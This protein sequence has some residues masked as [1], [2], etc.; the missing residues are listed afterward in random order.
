MAL[1]VAVLLGLAGFTAAP[2]QIVYG[3]GFA[4]SA[5][6]PHVRVTGGLLGRPVYP[7]PYPVYGFAPGFVGP[8]FPPP[9]GPSVLVPPWVYPPPLVGAPN[10][11]G[12]DYPAGPPV[13][14][15]DPPPAPPRGNPDGGPPGARP[16]QFIVISPKKDVPATAGN[17][18]IPEGTITPAVEKV[19]TPAPAARF[20]PST[21]AQTGNVEKSEADPDREFARLMKLA[22]EAFAGEEYGRAVGFLDR[23]AKAKPADALPHFLK[24]QALVATGQ[25]AEAVDAIRDGMRLA[26]DW[27]GGGFRPRE[28]YGANPGRFDAHLAALR[29]A[30][31]E[32]PGAA[33]L[34]FLLGYELWFGGNRA[35]ATELFAAA[36]RGAKNNPLVARFLKEAGKP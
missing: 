29:A 16:G 35:E 12:T 24:A 3:G 11:N 33:G 22:R 26:P 7:Y 28:L 36:G 34:Q 23:A 21:A 1:A 10:L 9:Y 15:R 8:Y 31:A 5:G 32:N 30:L 17:P 4:F 13:V 18:M 27:P 2:A 19:M 6:A 14:V 20:D 25:Y